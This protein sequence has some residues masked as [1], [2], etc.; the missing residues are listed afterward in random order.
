MANQP[1]TTVNS[2]ALDIAQLVRLPAMFTAISNVIAAQWIASNGNLD[3]W[4]LLLTLLASLCLYH[5]G[6]TLNDCFDSECDSRERPERPIPSGRVSLAW[7]WRFGSGLLAAGVLLA[8]SLG[9]TTGLIACA[10][11]AVIV[12][13]DAGSRQGW[14]AALNMG[15][16]RY[17]NWLLAL[18]VFGLNGSLALLALPIFCYVTALTRISQQEVDAAERRALVGA[19]VMVLLAAL[20]LATLFAF[21][22]LVNVAGLL[23]AALGFGLLAWRFGQL[24]RDFQPERIQAL[25]SSLVFGI[26]PLD[27]LLLLSAGFLWPALCLLLLLLPGKWLGRQLTVT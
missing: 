17:L 8:F 21:G 19:G 1:T 4:S 20:I 14:P 5:G 27:A 23:V 26:I 3:G 2:R 7:A 12:L 22:V 13:Y 6:M 24:A 18:S 16:C 9:V 10:L 15:L 25:V 11:A